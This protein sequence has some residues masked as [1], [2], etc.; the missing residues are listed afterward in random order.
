MSEYADAPPAANATAMF[1]HCTPY[2][3]G[4]DSGAANTPKAMTGPATE[5]AVNQSRLVGCDRTAE[6]S[7][8]AVIAAMGAGVSNPAHN[9]RPPR[10]PRLQCIAQSC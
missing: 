7:I 10:P 9:A 4:E 3:Y 2:P 8:T 5:D 6:A 1:N